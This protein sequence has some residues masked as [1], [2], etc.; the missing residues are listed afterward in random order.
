VPRMLRSIDFFLFLQQCHDAR[1]NG[2]ILCVRVAQALDRKRTIPTERPPLV[3]EVSA[4]F[5]GE[6]VSRG[7]RNGFPWPL[8]SV[9]LQLKFFENIILLR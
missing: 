9:T 5:C 4:N 6:R 7:Q 2:R 1:Y 8:I 3:G